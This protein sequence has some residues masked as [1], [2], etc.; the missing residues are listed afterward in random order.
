MSPAKAPVVVGVDGSEP[1]LRAAEAAAVEAALRGTALR[2]VYACRW[3]RYEGAALARDLGGPSGGVLPQDVVAGAVRRARRTRPALEIGSEVVLEEP[4]Y[5]LAHESRRAALVVVGNRGRGGL[6]EALLGSVS[7]TVAARAHC[8]VL[9]LRGG[10]G[11]PAAGEGPGP[12]QGHVVVGVGDR[13]GESE[14]VRFAC[15]E[16]RLRDVPVEAVRAWRCPVL[17]YADHPLLADNQ[18][19]VHREHAEKTLRDALTAVPPGAEVRARTAEGP[20]RRVLAE[21]S[22]GAGLLV[23]GRRR[24]GVGGFGLGRVVHFV[25]HHAHCAVAVVPAAPDEA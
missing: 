6:A 15:E 14:A 11:A 22:R 25:L 18:A 20:A 21:A 3:D 5:V 10:R 23:V 13:P 19:H 9:V 24:A 17:E 7:L 4:E 2:V 16:A 1:S 12:G 8:P